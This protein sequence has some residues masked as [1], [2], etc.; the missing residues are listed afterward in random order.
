MESLKT[1]MAL[2]PVNLAELKDTPSIP[3][4]YAS[5]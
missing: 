1:V 5:G 2:G 3:F 4:V